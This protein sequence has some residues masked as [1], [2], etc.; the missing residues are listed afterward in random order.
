[1]ILGLLSIILLNKNK[2]NLEIE[3]SETEATERQKYKW[4]FLTEMPII[5]V[6]SCVLDA[7]KYFKF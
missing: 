4:F 5:V 6:C 2:E 7:L 1:M 3:K